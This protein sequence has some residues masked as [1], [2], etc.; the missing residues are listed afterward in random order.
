[1]GTNSIAVFSLDCTLGAIE[2]RSC[3]SLVLWV[4]AVAALALHL[5]AVFFLSRFRLSGQ[6]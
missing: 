2:R 4:D 1:M 5:L 6:D 3:I